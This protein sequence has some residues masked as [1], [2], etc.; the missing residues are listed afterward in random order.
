MI[1]FLYALL[2]NCNCFIYVSNAFIFS[3]PMKRLGSIKE[4]IISVASLLSDD[5][6]RTTATYLVVDGGMGGGL[7]A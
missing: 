5:S 4:V 6:S 2:S 1:K 7:K 3:V